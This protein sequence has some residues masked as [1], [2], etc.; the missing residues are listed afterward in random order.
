MVKYKL[1]SANWELD[2]RPITE[3]AIV[4]DHVIPSPSLWDDIEKFKTKEV[5]S[6]VSL[7]GTLTSVGEVT[8]DVSVDGRPLQLRK[9]VLTDDAGNEV[10]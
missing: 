1:S 8:D 3:L 2:Y 7:L 10:N 5:D 9:I 4:S 6:V